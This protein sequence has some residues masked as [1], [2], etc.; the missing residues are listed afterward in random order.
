MQLLQRITPFSG[1]VAVR[2]KWDSIAEQAVSLADD[3]VE[4]DDN[5]LRKE[6][7]ALKYE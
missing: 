2:S 3:F 1:V 6:S 7:L 5:A 4:L